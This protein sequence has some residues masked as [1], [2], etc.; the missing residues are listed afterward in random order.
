MDA[1][2]IGHD[3]INIPDINRKS[4]GHIAIGNGINKIDFPKILKSRPPLK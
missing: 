4:I 1:I 3:S 2:A